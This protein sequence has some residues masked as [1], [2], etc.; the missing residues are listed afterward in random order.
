MSHKYTPHVFLA[1]PYKGIRG[2]ETRYIKFLE[3]IFWNFQE[4][5]I[6]FLRNLK[7]YENH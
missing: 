5:Q 3:T 4:F 6:I 2:F 7:A 1:F